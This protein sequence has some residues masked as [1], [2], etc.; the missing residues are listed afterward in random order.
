MQQKVHHIY[1][2]VKHFLGKGTLSRE[3]DAEITAQAARLKSELES[4][5]ETF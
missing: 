3:E 5:S 1:D 2:A 4:L